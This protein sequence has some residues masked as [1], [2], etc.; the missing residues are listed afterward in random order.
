MTACYI[1]YSEQV[2]LQH[3]DDVV[4][5]MSP[6]GDVVTEPVS[7]V[8]AGRDKSG[9]SDHNASSVQNFPQ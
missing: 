9:P 8:S 4:L 5:E 2:G 1:R 7:S 6:F 3:A